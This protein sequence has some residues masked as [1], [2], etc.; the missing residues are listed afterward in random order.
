MKT[1]ASMSV[2]DLLS[3]AGYDAFVAALPAEASDAIEELYSG[4]Q[5]IGD[6]Q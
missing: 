2:E 6:C 3:D 4:P 1:A 5:V